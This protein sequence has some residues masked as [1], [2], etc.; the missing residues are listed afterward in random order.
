MKKLHVFVSSALL[1]GITACSTTTFTEYRGQSLAQGKGG[2]IRTVE[3]IDFWENGDLIGTTDSWVLSTTLVVRSYLA[4][5][6]TVPLRNWPKNMVLMQS[7]WSVKL[8]NT[9]AAI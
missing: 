9:K 2:T 7:L 1:V 6:P 4:P 3:G 8:A 5:K